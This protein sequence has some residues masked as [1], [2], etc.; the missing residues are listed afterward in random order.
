[1]TAPTLTLETAE[2]REL[3]TRVLL[4]TMLMPAD[5]PYRARPVH[6]HADAAVRAYRER[7]APRGEPDDAALTF[8]G[9]EDCDGEPWCTLADGTPMCRYHAADAAL[10]GLPDDEQRILRSNYDTA[11]QGLRAQLAERCAPGASEPP[12]GRALTGAEEVAA[13]TLRASLCNDGPAWRAMNVLLDG[14]VRGEASPPPAPDPADIAST[15]DATP[16]EALDYARDSVGAPRDE[17]NVA[18]LAQADVWGNISMVSEVPLVEALAG[19]KVWVMECDHPDVVPGSLLGMGE[20][21]PLRT[22]HAPGKT[23]EP[24]CDEDGQVRLQDFTYPCPE[25]GSSS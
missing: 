10:E 20:V 25:H 17:G 21:L 2:E 12:R 19:G 14:I 9:Y 24:R 22:E 11:T 13:Q 6:E 5:T 18:S 4:Q 23:C 7:C 8:C 1:M 15:M 3:W 16:A